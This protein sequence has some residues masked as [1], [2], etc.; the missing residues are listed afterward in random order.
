M[1]TKIDYFKTDQL[2][3]TDM[4]NFPDCISLSERGK[5]ERLNIST[6]QGKNCTFLR[7]YRDITEQKLRWAKRLS[8]LGED[9]QIKIAKKY[10]SGTMPWRQEQLDK[11]T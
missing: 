10:Y 1:Q 6:C 11:N 9:D 5:C 3:N 4:L 2:S 7:T 8:D